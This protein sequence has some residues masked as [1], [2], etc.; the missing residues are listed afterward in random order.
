MKRRLAD[1]SWQRDH[2]KRSY[3]A[4]AFV[5]GLLIDWTFEGRVKGWVGTSLQF[6]LPIVLEVL[7]SA[8]IHDSY[9]VG[10]DEAKHRGETNQPG[11]ES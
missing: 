2:L 7:A 3:S 4:A 5:F 1:R 10:R 11:G 6:L 8:A 9:N